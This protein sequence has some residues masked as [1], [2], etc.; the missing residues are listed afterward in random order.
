MNLLYR[1]SLNTSFLVINLV[2]SKKFGFH[3]LLKYFNIPFVNQSINQITILP[4]FTYCKKV[5]WGVFACT[6]YNYKR[7][8]DIFKSIATK[9]MGEPLLDDAIYF[10]YWKRGKICMGAITLPS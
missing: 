9:S 5:I 8:F 6:F 2:Q 10:K 3:P 1:Y 7:N 4:H